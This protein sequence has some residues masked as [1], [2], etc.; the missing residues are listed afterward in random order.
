MRIRESLD[1]TRPFFSFE[2]FPPKSDDGA[3]TLLATIETLRPLRP[4]FVSITYGAGGST[5]LRTIELA[6]RISSDIGLVVMAHVTCVGSTRSEL[7][8]LFGDLADAGIENVLALRGDPPKGEAAFEVAPGGFAHAS[9]MA[10]MLAAEFDFCVGGA[11][12]PEKHPESVDPDADLV[13]LTTKVESGVEFLISQLFFDNER[14]FQFVRRARAVGITVPILPGIMPIT[15]YEQIARMTAMCGA[16]IPPKLL[17]A[18]GRRE[19]EREAV[20]DLGVAYATLQCFELLSRGAPGIHFYT[21]NR[22]PATR[23]VVSALLAANAWR[24]LTLSM[25]RPA[26]AITAS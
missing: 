9:D 15:N 7:R 23:A 1:S 20:E 13:N 22:S 21:L 6:K 4:A 24:D 2:F 18:L 11:C 10:K 3:A 17:A 12:Y 25:S 14:Y 19:G 5:R 16:S 8:E 26:P